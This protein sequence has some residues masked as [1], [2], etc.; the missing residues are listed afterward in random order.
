[1]VHRDLKP[2]NILILDS[3]PN[4]FKICLIDFGFVCWTN[5]SPEILSGVCGTPG[6]IAPEILNEMHCSPKS[7]IFSI[8]C[9]LYTM[10]SGVN[11]YLGRTSSE[12]MTN[13]KVEDPLK[14]IDTKH[15]ERLSPLFRDLILSMLDK[16]PHNR[17]TENQ[18]L[19]HPWFKEEVKSH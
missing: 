4:N 5:E 12:L 10:V 6:F 2:E 17:P 19:S 11:V 16:N 3:N 15:F 7:D 13:N 8:G 18:S 9:I 14:F 1:M